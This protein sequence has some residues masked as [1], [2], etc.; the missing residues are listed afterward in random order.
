MAR[1]ALERALKKPGRVLTWHLGAG[2]RSYRSSDRE[3]YFTVLPPELAG[4]VQRFGSDATEPEVLELFLDDML[5]DLA[6]EEAEHRALHGDDPLV[7]A[8]PS[9]AVLF[10]IRGYFQGCLEFYVTQWAAPPRDPFRRGPEPRW[11]ILASPNV[12]SVG[13]CAAAFDDLLDRCDSVARCHDLVLDLE[14]VRDGFRTMLR[15]KT[16]YMPSL[17]PAAAALR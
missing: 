6:V 10:E 11:L 15:R 14:T 16:G 3:D 8:M 5:H 4:F 13:R 1:V 9:D 7:P 2:C 17:V 12:R